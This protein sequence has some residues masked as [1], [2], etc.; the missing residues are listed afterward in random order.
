[1]LAAL[2]SFSMCFS[3]WLFWLCLNVFER[4]IR[5]KCT[6]FCPPVHCCSFLRA[7]VSQL[8]GQLNVPPSLKKCKGGNYQ[9]DVC[10]GEDC[11]VRSDISSGCHLLW[12]QV[13]LL[14]YNALYDEENYCVLSVLIFLFWW[15]CSFSWD[16]CLFKGVFQLVDMRN[17]WRYVCCPQFSCMFVWATQMSKILQHS[18]L[19]K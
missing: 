16:F 2:C 4:W 5:R 18:Y 1:M 9:G 17:R 10:L 15:A 11:F 19:G 6:H 13:S 14:S 7:A 12:H 3:T 8:G